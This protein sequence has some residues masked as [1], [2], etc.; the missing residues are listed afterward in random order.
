MNGTAPEGSVPLILANH[1]GS[2]D[3]RQYVDEIGLLELAGKEHFAIVAPEEQYIFTV[4]RDILPDFTRYILDKYPALD[5]SRVYVTGY[6]MGGFATLNAIFGDSS[7]FAA[8][9][10]QAGAG[11][12]PTEENELQYK[13]IDLPIM[14]FHSEYDLFFYID[15]A[16][17]NITDRVKGDLNRFLRYNEMDELE[18]DFE[19]YPINGF[20]GDRYEEKLLNGEHLNRCWT[21]LND[22][23]VPMVAFNYTCDLQH[24][25]YPEYAKLIWDYCK[26]FSRD[27]ETGA[28]IYNPYAE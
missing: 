1:G 18:F 6:S 2:D 11:I 22:E 9:A 25:L 14:I 3:P 27:L 4:L 19:A 7:I 17:G 12:P 23:G 24:A 10:P 21:M 8:A 16:T 20:E 15:P 26:Q 5:R 28:V 13:D